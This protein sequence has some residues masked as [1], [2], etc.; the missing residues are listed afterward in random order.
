[1]V[2]HSSILY[3]CWIEIKICSKVE[4]KIRARVVIGVSSRKWG[5]YLTKHW[6][7]L[8]KI[9]GKHREKIVE[10]IDK[11]ILISFIDDQTKY[12]TNKQIFFSNKYFIFWLWNTSSW[13][14]VA[15]QGNYYNQNDILTW[16]VCKKNWLNLELLWHM[17]FRIVTSI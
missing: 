3:N 6:Q 4:S 12:E 10:E 15:M 11:F 17:G 16:R 5:R 13:N 2:C 1:M 9:Y 14:Y 7:S 8:W